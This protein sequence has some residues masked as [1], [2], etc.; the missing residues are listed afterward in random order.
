MQE[1]GYFLVCAMFGI[2]PEVALGM[3]LIRRAREVILGLPGVFV[4]VRMEVR[5]GASFSR[6][7]DYA[8]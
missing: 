4:W 1:G 6:N 7:P 3:S 2:G 5:A 8:P